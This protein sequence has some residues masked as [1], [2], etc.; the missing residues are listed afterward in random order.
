[1]SR[2]LKQSAFAA[3]F[4]LIA[5]AAQATPL[6]G[7]TNQDFTQYTGAAPKNCF[8]CVNPVGWTGGSGLIYID[9][10]G[11]ATSST[12][13][14]GVYGPFSN[15]PTG[16]NFVEADGNPTFESGFNYTVHGLTVGQTYT[17]SF[18]QAGGQQAGFANGQ[19]TTERWI[20]ALGT[21]GLSVS[22]SGGPVDPIYGPTGK[23]SDADP[24]A[25]I[26]QSQLMTTPSGGVT[27]WQ[28]VSVNLKADATTDVLS[29]LAW[30]DNGSTVNLPPMVFLSGVDSPNV[31][32]EPGS[33]ALV[34][35]AM[36]GLVAA[37]RKVK[38]ASPGAAA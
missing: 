13:G 26:E 29:F 6:P 7:L 10:P 32:P 34:G 2:A 4:T 21:A 18:Y 38:R 33:V 8:S 31:L 35:L 20:V 12:G 1:M 28:F 24:N 16:G 30:G 22:T 15:P 23:Y 27:P 11:T 19:P 14:I 9:A 25:D 37:S 3:A 17:L 36:L 5:C